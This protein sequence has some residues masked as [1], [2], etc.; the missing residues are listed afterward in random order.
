MTSRSLLTDFLTRP[1]DTI[2]RE[3]MLHAKVSHDIRLY[4]AQY[5]VQI[6]MTEPDIDN[7]GYDFT[8]ILNHYNFPIQNKAAIRPGGARKWKIRASLLKLCFADRDLAPYLDGLKVSGYSEGASGGILLHLIDRKESDKGTL[9]VSYK[10]L[11]IFYI[12]GIAARHFSASKFSPEDA[13]QLLRTLRDS[14]DDTTLNIPERYFF[15]ISTSAAIIAL[16]FSLPPCNYV[17]QSKFKSD[18][19]TTELPARILVDQ[20][21]KLFAYLRE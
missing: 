19:S 21:E 6:Q 10:Y 14:E 17:V 11:D 3:K 20:Y 15:P 5:G 1:A 7:R 2:A 16:R 18:L 13:I 9:A 12:I 8:L 4:G